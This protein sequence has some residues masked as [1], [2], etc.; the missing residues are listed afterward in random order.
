VVQELARRHPLLVR[1]LVLVAT[2][3]GVGAKPAG[4]KVSLTLL[5]TRRYSDAACAARDIPVLAGGRTARDPAILAGILAERESYP[6]SRR[7]YR[8]QQWAAIGWG[9]RRWLSELRVPTLVL[10]GDEDPAVPVA[11]ARMLADRIPGSEL[12]IVPGAGHMLL[13]D[14]TEKAAT[15]LERFLA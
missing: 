2:I 11:N 6:P 4:L 9:S 14:E 3:M 5:S 8:Y 12:E 1:R 10:H 15:I 13:F 7:A